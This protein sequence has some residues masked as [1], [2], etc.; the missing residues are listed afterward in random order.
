MNEKVA[1]VVFDKN[2]EPKLPSKEVQRKAREIVEKSGA[3]SEQRF[4]RVVLGEVP[5]GDQAKV[6]VRWAT[7]RDREPLKGSSSLEAALNKWIL[8]CLGD[9]ISR[10]SPVRVWPGAPLFQ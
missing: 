10:E 3:N 5:F 7:T 6:Y 4:N 9:L 2:G 1:P 8:P